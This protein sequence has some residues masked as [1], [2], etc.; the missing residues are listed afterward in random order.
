M[1][2]SSSAIVLLCRVYKSVSSIFR[3]HR[4]DWPTWTYNGFEIISK[5]T[6]KNRFASVENNIM[7]C[8]NYT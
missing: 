6:G 3:F 5:T 1:R 7:F 2:T 8:T 4:I